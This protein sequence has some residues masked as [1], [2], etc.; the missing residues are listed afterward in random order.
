MDE[1]LR[2]TVLKSEGEG[3][4]EACWEI[5]HQ[6]QSERMC[7]KQSMIVV[8]TYQFVKI[9]GRASSSSVV[10]EGLSCGERRSQTPGGCNDRMHHR[11]HVRR[12][13]QRFS[14]RH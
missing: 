14:P 2:N 7:S 4:R 10:R 1:V 11:Q 9:R 3:H 12:W 13:E 8:S 5:L 6:Q